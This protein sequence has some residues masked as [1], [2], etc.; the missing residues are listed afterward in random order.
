MIVFGRL[1]CAFARGAASA[2]LS[3]VAC[4][5][6]AQTLTMP[7]DPINVTPADRD[8]GYVVPGAGPTGVDGET[9]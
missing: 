4:A 5:S 1:R 3:L 7:G 8:T 6:F 2:L 9:K